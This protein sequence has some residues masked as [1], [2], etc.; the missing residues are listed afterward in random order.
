MTTL[1]AKRDRLRAPTFRAATWAEAE[2][3]LRS[4]LR[5]MGFQPSAIDHEIE[6][7]KLAYQR[8]KEMEN[9]IKE[10]EAPIRHRIE[11]MPPDMQ[12]EFIRNLE[13]AV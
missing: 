5:E 10:I 8:F 7:Q 4:R 1:L 11:K 3:I 12:E 9:R 2:T 13:L 6:I